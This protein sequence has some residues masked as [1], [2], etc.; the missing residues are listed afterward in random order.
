MCFDHLN[1]SS[2]RF[3]T[4]VFILLSVA[5]SAVSAETSAPLK[6]NEAKFEADGEVTVDSEETVQQE[7]YNI[8]KKQLF[9][10]FIMNL[11]TK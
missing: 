3:K 6:E 8:Y 11:I 9:S 1:F 7:D 10:K 5:Y 2:E 4:V